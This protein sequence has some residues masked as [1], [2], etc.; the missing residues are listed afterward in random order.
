VNVLGLRI[1]LVEDNAIIRE[2]L[3]AALAELANTTL[4][5]TADGEKAAVAWLN[6]HP[7]DWDLA[8][9]D[10]FLKEGN[11]IGVVAAGNARRVDQKLVVLTNYASKGVRDQC[12]KLGADAV[13]DKSNDIDTL[14]EFCLKQSAES[15]QA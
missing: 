3:A 11:G 5:G 2:N 9:V 10:I 12:L 6:A 4:C 1:Y 14:V 7:D 13:F 8:I 15:Q